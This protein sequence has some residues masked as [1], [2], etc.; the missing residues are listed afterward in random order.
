MYVCLATVE[1]VLQD[2]PSGFVRQSSYE[3]DGSFEIKVPM[4]KA[5]S[6]RW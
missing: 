3:W 1:P 2:H 5:H 4:G 6:F